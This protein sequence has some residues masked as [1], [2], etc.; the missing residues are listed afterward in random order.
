MKTVSLC[1]LFF[2]MTVRAQTNRGVAIVNR[3]NS[4]L[5]P[6]KSLQSIDLLLID[7]ENQVANRA[8]V[9]K[10]HLEQNEIMLRS[11]TRCSSFTGQPLFN[12]IW[13]TR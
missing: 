12:G 1:V 10:Q 7:T 2:T 5:L 4:H 3:P 9:A 11:R 6:L 13:P 8:A